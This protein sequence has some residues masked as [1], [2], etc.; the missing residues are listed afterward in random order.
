MV[1]PLTEGVT[2]GEVVLYET[3]MAY[4]RKLLT[5]KQDSGATEKLVIGE[6]LEDNTGEIIVGTG[7]NCDAVLLEEVDLVTLKAGDCSRVCLVKGPAIID[8]D[9]VNVAS[10]Q[11]T[12]A[13]VAL[14]ALGINA[15]TEP[16]YTTAP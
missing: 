3:P 2:I 10:A 15:R 6:L 11:K 4:S 1:T 12:T 7:S 8:S 14:L 13:L 16:T 5:I 9:R